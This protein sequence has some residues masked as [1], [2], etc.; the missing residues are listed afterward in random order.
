GGDEVLVELLGRHRLERAD[1]RGSPA[2]AHVAVERELRDGEEP[3]ADLEEAAVHL[4]LVVLE[5]AEGHHLV[6]EVRDILRSVAGAGSDEDAEPA[7]DATD[8]RAVD[9]HLGAAH[10][11]NDRPH[12][13]IAPSLRRP[14]SMSARCTR[15]RG[16]APRLRR[17]SASSA[18]SLIV[19][20][21]PRC[22]GLAPCRLAVLA[23]GVAPLASGEGRPAP[24]GRSSL[25]RFLA[26]PASLHVGSLYSPP[27]SRPSP[28]AR[29]G[30][31]R[32]VA[33]A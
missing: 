23:S 4:A 3:A 6:D 11:L 10:P 15:L 26:A 13:C 7:T 28:P 24:L 2:L 22:A 9:A 1:E 32:S 14:R 33:Q 19:A 27:G 31:L 30:Q 8:D 16:R 12:R 29:V 25:H 18:R 20:S 5:D 17:G 21:L